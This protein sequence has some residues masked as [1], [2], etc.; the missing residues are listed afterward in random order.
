M[1]HS[2]YRLQHKIYSATDLTPITIA[3]NCPPEEVV[4]TITTDNRKEF[5]EHRKLVQFQ[6]E[7][8]FAPP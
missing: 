2:F 8:Y 4:R 7:I 3:P 6:P 5:M 1:H